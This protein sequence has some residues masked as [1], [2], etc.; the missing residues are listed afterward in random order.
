MSAAGEDPPIDWFPFQPREGVRMGRRGS[1]L[2]IEWDGIGRLIAT[3]SGADAHF[4]PAEGVDASVLAKF[5]ATSLLACQR[6]L[7][8]AL[9]LHGSAV[10][11][12]SGAVVLVGDNGAGKSTAAMALVAY[13]DAA[14]MADDIVPIDWVGGVPVVTPVEDALWLMG[15]ASAS[16]GLEPPSGE[17]GPYVPRSRAGAPERL[18]AIVHLTFDESVDGL[19]FEPLLGQETFLVLSQAQVC[20]SSGGDQET[21]SQLSTRAH[22]A[23]AVPVVRLRR[24]RSL[25]ALTVLPVALSDHIGTLRPSE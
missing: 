21:L 12:A 20:Y 10:R 19:A 13:G 18:A 23:D 1:H 7:A 8:G 22:L 16:F 15:D 5:R 4:T 2:A 24:R 17:K 6:Y 11:L 25:D 3:P 9:S 14:F